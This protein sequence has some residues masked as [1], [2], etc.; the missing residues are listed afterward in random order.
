M[1]LRRSLCANTPA[2]E[3]P[4]LCSNTGINKSVVRINNS[5]HNDRSALVVMIYTPTLCWRLDVYMLAI[6]CTKTVWES[7]LE[8]EVLRQWMLLC[9]CI[10]ALDEKNSPKMKL[11]RTQF[12]YLHQRD[13][14]WRN[15]SDNIARNEQW[16]RRKMWSCNYIIPSD[17]LL[18][19]LVQVLTGLQEDFRDSCSSNPILELQAAECFPCRSNQAVTKTKLIHSKANRQW[20]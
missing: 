20:Q 13:Y 11:L 1:A 12:R 9:L 15:G 6:K 4:P 17:V 19:G 14:E 8:V 16:G 3:D 10:G 7:A 2:S 5:H 18:H